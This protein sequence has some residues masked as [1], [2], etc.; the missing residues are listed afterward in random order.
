MLFMRFNKKRKLK[1]IIG[2]IAVCIFISIISFMSWKVNCKAEK[3]KTEYYIMGEEVA[4]DNNFFFDNSEQTYGYSVCVNNVEIRDYEEFFLSNCENKEDIPD[5]DARSQSICLVNMTI[6][7]NGNA[8]GFINTMGMI[9]YNGAL[10]IQVDYEIWN[11]IDKNIDGNYILKLRENSEATLTIPFTSQQLDEYI[12]S[13]RL[14]K[15][16]ES[17]KLSIVLAEYPVRK[18]VKLYK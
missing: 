3:Q 13:E 16:L 4:L 14:N 7:N 18:V 17:K 11:L 9:L 10:Q 12:D 1:F 15:I 6:K 5:Y 2:L 8:N